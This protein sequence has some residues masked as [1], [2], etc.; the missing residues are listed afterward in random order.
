VLAERNLV[1]HRLELGER[2]KRDANV[3][4]VR[5]LRADPACGLARRARCERVALEKND[6]RDAE[7]AEMKRGGGADGAA[8]DDNDVCRASGSR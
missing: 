8:A 2:A 6:V 4:L 3:Q 7:T 1:A 5:E